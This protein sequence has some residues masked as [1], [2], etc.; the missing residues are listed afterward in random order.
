MKR[1]LL[2]IILPVLAG[3][4][5]VGT[6]FSTWYFT[7]G[8]K[9]ESIGADVKLVGYAN[10]GTI[11]IAD[12]NNYVLKVDSS[13]DENIHLINT[14][15]E[16]TTSHTKDQIDGVKINY[17]TNNGDFALEV[18]KNIKVTMNVSIDN[19]E[20]Y[21]NDNGLSSYINYS[22]TNTNNWVGTDNSYILTISPESISGSTI[23]VTAPVFSF[24]FKD[25]KEPTT[26]GTW[27]DLY[28]AVT[29]ASFN[30]TFTAEWANK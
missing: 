25:K 17:T 11:E 12:V 28:K 1:K 6:G 15:T 7:D 21:S 18:E 20:G 10:L 16:T 22:V 3:V 8:M 27:D 4:A 30:I 26:P 14:A 24:S 5:V 19:G 2:G 13:E 29:A 23:N 9:E